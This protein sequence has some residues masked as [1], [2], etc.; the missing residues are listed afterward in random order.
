MAATARAWVGTSGWNYKH[1]SN[2]VF[3][4]EGLK[5]SGWLEF[6]ARH[7]DTVEIN[8]TFY[9]LARKSVFESWRD[10]SPPGFL[11]AV[12]VYRYITHRKKLLEIEETLP[13]F[14]ENA[15][16]LGDKLGPLLFQLPPRWHYNGERLKAL[17]DY[18][19]WQ[20]LLPGARWALEVRDESWHNDELFGLLREHNVALA[21]TD[22]PGFAALGPLTTDFVYVRRHGPK[23]MYTSNYSEDLLQEDAKKIREWTA[24]GREVFIYFN[25]DAQGFAIKNALR[26]KELLK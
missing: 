16:G 21:L 25:N 17:L 12:K 7:F 8:N 19:D 26:L 13:P 4:P 18:M 14:L 6:Y 5:A 15:A 11:F 10:G 2:G 24:G 1:W 23:G 9:N 22:Q 20:R 3:Y